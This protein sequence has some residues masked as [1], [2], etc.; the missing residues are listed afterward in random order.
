MLIIE[1]N[2]SL[3]HHNT[4]HIDA[5]AK[6]FAEINSVDDLI[7]LTLSSIIKNNKSLILGAGANTLFV[8]DFNGI[9]IHSKLDKISVIEDSD[10]YAIVQAGSGCKWDDLVSYALDNNFF[11]IENLISI[12][13]LVGASPVQNIG[14]YGCEQKDTFYSLDAVN[15]QTGELQS[16]SN[17][18][19]KFAYRDSIFKLPENHNKYF[20]INVRYKLSKQPSLNYDYKDIKDRMLRDNLTNIDAKQLAL[21]ISNIR[22]EKLPDTGLLGS[23]GSFF[24]NPFISQEKAIEL[25]AIFENIPIYQSKDNKDSGND[26]STLFK[27]SAAFLIEKVGLKGYR[28]GDAG[29]YDKHS[30]ILVNYGN[31]SGRDIFNLANYVVDKVYSRFQILL[32]P[33]A[34]FVL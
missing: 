15:I 14:A 27:V 11:G 22:S 5:K 9:I 16:F 17:E 25:K 8:E 33:E 32:E 31:A 29:V 2:K 19:C 21:L 24:K 28:I 4:F 12:P 3:K 13:G 1:E 10:D 23:A 7:E 34:I 20:I 26:P 18:E 6:F 30:L